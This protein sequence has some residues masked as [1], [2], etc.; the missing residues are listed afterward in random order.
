MLNDSANNLPEAVL[1]TIIYS[2][3]FDYPLT[4]HQIHRYLAEVSA[5]FEEVVKSLD[6]SYLTHISDYFTLPG[7]EEIVSIRLEREARS[8][9]LLPRAIHYGRILG[10]LPFIRMVALTGS[11]AVMNVS[12]DQDFDYMLVTTPG[13]LWTARAF[14][15]AFNRLV[16]IFGHTICPNLIISETRLEWRLHDLYSARELCQMIPITGIDVYLKLMNANEWVRGFLPNAFRESNNLL[17]RTVQEHTLTSIRAPALQKLLELPLRGTMGNKLES[18]E[19]N[20]KIARF[21]TQ[22]GFGEETNFNAEICQG[23]F[24]HHRK[25][26]REAF[27]ERLMNI[28]SPVPIGEG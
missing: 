10:T 6:T 11:L 8:R 18:W 21:S 13:R 3:I 23:N 26:T 25:W 15:L 1:R 16:R 5:S 9:A 14:A 4:A 22:V 24:H 7:R 19:M 12:T 2:D 20:R 27:E 17:V 28:N